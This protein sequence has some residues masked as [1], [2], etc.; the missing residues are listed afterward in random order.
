MPRTETTV[1]ELYQ[2]DELDE[3][4]KD[5]ARDWLRELK[6]QDFD[7]EYLYED[8]ERVCT[9]LGITLSTQGEGGA[10]DHSPNVS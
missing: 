9:I 7:H 4:A 2:F 1:R 5:R 10:W 6:A 3:K 8:A